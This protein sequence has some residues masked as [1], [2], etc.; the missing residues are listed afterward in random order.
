M[1]YI[2]AVAVLASFILSSCVKRSSVEFSGIT[3]GIK[4]GV[5]IV[6]TT[7][8]SV[9]YGENIKDGKFSIPKKQLQLP[10]YYMMNVTD[11][12]NNDNHAAFEIYLEDGK[13]TIETEAGKLYKYPKI[14]SPSKIQDQLSAFYTLSDK[15]SINSRQEVD[16]L[17]AEIKAKGNKLSNV[18]YSQL[19]NLLGAAETKMLANNETTF[20]EFVKEYPKSDIAAHLMARL[21]YE[22]DPLTYYAIYKTLSPAAKNSDE[23]KEL[24]EKLSHLVKLVVGATAPPIYGKTVDGKTFDPKTLGKKYILVDFWRASNDFSRRNHETLANILSNQKSKGKFG[25]LSVSFDK[26]VD[27]WTNAINEDHMTWPQVSDLKGDDSPNAVNWS[28]STIPTYY[29]LD[30]NWKIVESNIEINRLDFEINDYLEKH[31]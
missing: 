4:R 30:S 16:R 18:A 13:Y 28:I 17:N 5:F 31:R 2:F 24:G 26:K 7:A 15:V 6:K 19:L 21:N 27:W 20:T 25:I 10:G 23:G 1:K 8:D 29:L 11:D 14:A 22:D 12:A 3:P 9:I